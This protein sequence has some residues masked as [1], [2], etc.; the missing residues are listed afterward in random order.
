M[1]LR[2][3]ATSREALN[4]AGELVWSVP[5]LSVP[6]PDRAPAVEELK[7]LEAVRL[8]VERARHR[9]GA[10]SLTPENAE[11]VAGICRRLDGIPLAIELAAAKVG[12]LSVEQILARL[13][14]SLRLLADDSQ[15]AP[16]RQRTLKGT[17]DWSLDLLSEPE[18][19]LFGRLAVFAGGWTLEAAEAVGKGDGIEDDD[20]V[21]EPL[22]GLV[23]K[24][25]VVA[26]ARERGEVRYR[27]LEPVR[28]YGRESLEES[29]EAGAAHGRHAAYFLALVERVDPETRGPRQGAWLEQLQKEHDNFRAALSWALDGEG[30]GRDERAEL[31]LRLA[32]ALGQGGFWV[33]YGLGEGLGWL[34][35]GLARSS[36]SPASL[37][38]RA[39]NEA[40]WIATFRGDYEKVVTLLEECLI[41]FKEL[42][43]KSGLATSLFRLGHA[44]LHQGDHARVETVRKEAEDLRPELVDRQAITYLL[45]F[46]A[47]AALDES[48]Y[49]RMEALTEESMALNR[50]LGDMRGIGMCLTFLMLAALERGD[51]ERAAA[52]LEEDLRLLQELK[53]KAGIVYGLL[54]TA[55]VAAL[56]GE[57]ARAA[58]LWGATEALREAIAFPMTAFDRAHYDYEGYVARARSQL[59]NAAA[60]ET[61]W[62]Q[63]RTMTPE[64]AIEYALSEEEPPT[65]A[66]GAPQSGTKPSLTVRER[67]V[68][69]L[70]AKEMT[71]RQIAEELVISERTVSTH[72]RRIL[73]KLGL[74]SRVQI[75]A[76]VVEQRLLP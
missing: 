44:A 27:L 5:A 74:R 42:G 46:L 4:V 18:K 50:E 53:E 20:E 29:G 30:A 73:E 23:E 59:E 24:S 71:N 66:P 32:T 10:F 62:A 41:L 12:T 63:G 56:R 3:L 21:L 13:E 28:Q 76:W 40:S 33:A 58:R 55:A 70:L 15:T 2:I 67:E 61:A 68:A 47:M 75:A 69:L 19:G 35:R 7:G 48:D 31:G 57:A 64:Q 45:I 22:L 9:E 39:L 6:E 11:A 25:L 34:E 43:D 36:A 1:S 54:G 72:V 16:P 17:L 26:E 60:W 52:L 38:T 14:D 49:G 65:M 37:R 51:H 8:F